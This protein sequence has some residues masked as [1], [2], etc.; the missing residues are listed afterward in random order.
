MRL[1]PVQEVPHVFTRRTGWPHSSK[2]SLT[3]SKAQNKHW[4]VRFQLAGD[5]WC[6][7][8][9][10]SVGEGYSEFLADNRVYLPALLLFEKVDDTTL[11]V[12]IHRDNAL[13]A[14]EPLPPPPYKDDRPHFL[15][16]LRA[17]HVRPLKSSRMV[18]EGA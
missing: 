6:T 9:W 18:S 7:R 13:P 11:A 10:V 4:P 14:Q 5:P 3:T 1:L 16:T 2:C 8:A 15:K 17:C 12:T